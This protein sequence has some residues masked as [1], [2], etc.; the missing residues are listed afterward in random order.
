MSTVVSKEKSDE[1]LRT[2]T[3]KLREPEF[4]N[5]PITPDR[6]SSKEWADKEWEKIWTKTWQI[7]GVAAQL[8]KAGDWITADFGPETIVCIQ[9]E[10]GEVRAFYNVCQHRG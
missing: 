3:S 7:A 8:A 6:Y 10:D 4:R 1:A 9:G 2:D 5:T